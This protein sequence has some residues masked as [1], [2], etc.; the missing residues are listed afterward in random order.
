MPRNPRGV[1]LPLGQRPGGKLL[2][3]GRGFLAGAANLNAVQAAARKERA[4]RS[5]AEKTAAQALL[6][7][8][9]HP[10]GLPQLRRGG[11]TE[12][13]TQREVQVL[14][15][16]AA[17]STP[18]CVRSL[19]AELGRSESCI[20]KGLKR[21]LAPETPPDAVEPKR[22][23]GGRPRTLTPEESASLRSDVRNDPVG[24]ARKAAEKL[25]ARTGKK[26]SRWTIARALCRGDCPGDKAVRKHGTSR[27]APLSP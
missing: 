20:R 2:P 13:L 1:P 18:V 24:G 27:Y 6:T 16:R 25:Y 7:Q 5:A 26:P 10:G 15:M 3:R 14:R 8:S 9:F 23:R 17:G 4:A 22:R 21:A 19:A 11:R 12:P